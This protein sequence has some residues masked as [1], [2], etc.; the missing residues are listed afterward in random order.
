MGIARAP[1]FAVCSVFAFLLVVSAGCN[2]F[3]PFNNE[4]ESDDVDALIVDARQALAAGD[5]TSAVRIMERALAR[6][7]EQLRVRT[8]LS[9]SLLA[10]DSVDTLTIQDLGQ[11]VAETG[12]GTPAVGASGLCSFAAAT[13]PTVPLAIEE[14]ASYRRIEPALNVLRR[15][16]ELLDV[17]VD[18]TGNSNDVLLAAQTL[19]IQGI[20]IIGVAL[21]ELQKAALL[22]RATLHRLPDNRIGYCTPTAEELQMMLI[23]AG[24]QTRADLDRA[25]TIL[26]LRLQLLRAPASSVAG[27]LL[28]TAEAAR[29]AAAGAVTATCP[30]P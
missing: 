14:A 4:G 18:G 1:A 8:L 20:A 3:S 30:T 9:T 29:I 10:R 24:C 2:P 25:V 15:I 11:V 22:T 13:T 19:H 5:A 27:D 7:P 21:V 6:D 17:R 28:E 26:R 23:T 12:G 16:H